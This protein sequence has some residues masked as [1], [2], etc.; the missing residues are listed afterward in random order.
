[1]CA[2]RTCITHFEGHY[3]LDEE[4]HSRQ[5]IYFRRTRTMDYRL[6][7]FDLGLDSEF[8]K[9]QVYETVTY[10]PPHPVKRTVYYLVH[11]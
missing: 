9:L 10:T 6:L 2:R 8:P 11:Y 7:Q 5:I 3:L 1:M 4:A